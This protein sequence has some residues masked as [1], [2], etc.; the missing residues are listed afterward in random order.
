MSRTLHSVREASSAGDWRVFMQDS[1]S[2]RSVLTASTLAVAAASLG[3]PPIAAAEP[4]NNSSIKAGE[5]EMSS[6]AQTAIVPE[7]IREPLTPENSLLFYVD[8]Q[9]QYVFSV[10][11]INAGTLIN[12]AAGLA[13]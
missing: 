1:T 3:V 11:T 12:N 13:K 5:E 2:R 7:G 4:M 6:A 9:P 10:H 8:L